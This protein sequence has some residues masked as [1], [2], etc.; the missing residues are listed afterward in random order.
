[1]RFRFKTDQ[2]R[3]GLLAAPA[4]WVVLED[5]FELALALLVQPLGLQYETEEEMG[6]QVL[7]V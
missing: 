6:L 3:L 5:P 7:W 1:M 4:Q 2:R